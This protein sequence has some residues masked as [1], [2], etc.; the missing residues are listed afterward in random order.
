MSNP[1]DETFLHPQQGFLSPDLLR[2]LGAYLGP[3]P[4][5]PWTPARR[6]GPIIVSCFEQCAVYNEDGLE[7]RTRSYTR[8]GEFD[9]T[10]LV[11]S[12][13]AFLTLTF[14]RSATLK[15]HRRTTSAA[16][17]TMQWCT[18]PVMKRRDQKRPHNTFLDCLKEL[19]QYDG[20]REFLSKS[21]QLAAISVLDLQSDMNDLVRTFSLADAGRERNYVTMENFSRKWHRLFFSPCYRQE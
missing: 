18:Q 11:G 17:T 13:D 6:H 2:L 1:L 20:T 4:H 7:L 21:R 12:R 9:M 15:L 5:D 14:P 19:R 3:P 8:G 10:L 16:T